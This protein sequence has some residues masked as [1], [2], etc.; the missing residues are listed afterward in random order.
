MH[1]VMRS[2]RA[3]GAWSL[4]AKPHASR[5]E[6]L[7][8]DLGPRFGV[9]VYRF[10]NAGNHLHLLIRGRTRAGIQNYLRT[11]AALIARAVTRACRG[12]PV[13]KF[14]DGLAW[15]RVVGWGR[16]F[17]TTSRYLLRNTLEALGFA[18]PSRPDGTGVEQAIRLAEMGVRLRR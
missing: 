16:D 2:S 1:V 3:R 8:R 14:W 11:A 7:A 18:D 9:R 15:S 4:N 12:R 10:A 5:V 6:R 17:A 13:G